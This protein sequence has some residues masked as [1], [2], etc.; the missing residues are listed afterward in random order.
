MESG[1]RRTETGEFLLNGVVQAAGI[2]CVRTWNELRA[3]MVSEWL[4]N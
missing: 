4:K 3:R 1:E 2:V